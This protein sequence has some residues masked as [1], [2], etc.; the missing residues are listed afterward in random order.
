M[1]WSTDIKEDKT[2]QG[3]Y[4]IFFTELGTAEIDCAKKF[5]IKNKIYRK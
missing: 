3:A 5:K 4:G 2:P 1:E